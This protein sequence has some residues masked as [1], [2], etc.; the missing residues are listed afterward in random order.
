MSLSCCASTSPQFLL[1]EQVDRAEALALAADAVEFFFDFA[2]RRQLGVGLEL[3]ELRRAGRFNVEE[4]ADFMFD[5]GEAA[6]GAIA[7][8]LSAR[9]F[10][11]GFADRLKRGARGFIG[12]GKVRFSLRQP[13]GGVAACSCRRLDLADQGLTLLGEFLRRVV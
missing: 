10:G 8:F 12:G 5:V 4:V 11:A 2:D 6:L 3:G 7:A 1:G 13:V 9:G